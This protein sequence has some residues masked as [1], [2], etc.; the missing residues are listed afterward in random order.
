[1]FNRFKGKV[2]YR[3]I[4]HYSPVIKLGHNFSGHPVQ[5]LYFSINGLVRVFLIYEIKWDE[6]SITAIFLS[7]FI[8]IHIPERGFQ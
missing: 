3:F 2:Q 6:H 1:M 8:R 7:Q 5:G 4:T